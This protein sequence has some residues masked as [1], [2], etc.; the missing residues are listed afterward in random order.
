MIKKFVFFILFAFLVLPVFSAKLKS[1]KTKYVPTAKQ[2]A[3][4]KK[5]KE[6]LTVKFRG[7][8]KRDEPYEL[9]GNSFL[10][11]GLRPLAG[12]AVL[13]AVGI[14]TW[15]Q[16]WE[17][18]RAPGDRSHNFVQF[19]L[20]KGKGYLLPLDSYIPNQP[21]PAPQKR[22]LEAYAWDASA[23]FA[24]LVT[25]EGAAQ[26]IE[27]EASLMPKGDRAEYI[28]KK[29]TVVYEIKSVLLPEGWVYDPQAQSDL[30]FKN[31]HPDSAFSWWQDNYLFPQSAKGTVGNSTR[32]FISQK[33]GDIVLSKDGDGKIKEDKSLSETQVDYQRRKKWDLEMNRHMEWMTHVDVE[34]NLLGVLSLSH[35]SRDSLDIGLTEYQKD[36]LPAGDK[37][38]Y[39]LHW[40]ENVTDYH[41]GIRH[42]IR[43]S[44]NPQSAGGYDHWG[45]TRWRDF[46]DYGEAVPFTTG[47]SVYRHLVAG[48]TVN[49]PKIRAQY[50]A[51]P[52][53]PPVSDKANP[54]TVFLSAWGFSFQ[55]ITQEAAKKLPAFGW[56]S[57]TVVNQVEPKSAAEVAG[58]VP[59]DIIVFFAADKIESGMDLAKRLKEGHLSQD[60]VVIFWRDGVYLA[61][62]LDAPPWPLTDG[63]D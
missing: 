2:V 31:N 35:P 6:D 11:S 17:V 54:V 1:T 48:A 19:T 57:G 56:P 18:Q 4:M 62:R 46:S 20:T 21:D 44:S 45:L 14:H 30:V 52:G 28:D 7:Q 47:I 10:P 24:W 58:L 3:W 63:L 29:K 59:G 22:T 25:P 5:Y 36:F 26:T 16:S 49:F 38:S 37:N 33:G 39:T 32:V 23:A 41:D 9:T 60:S 8:D 12:K 40:G 53:K 51:D 27:V 55:D 50:A 15:N 61:G 43:E 34:D 13:L 42:E